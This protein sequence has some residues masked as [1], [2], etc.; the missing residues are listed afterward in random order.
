M[1]SFWTFCF[2]STGS[3]ITTMGQPKIKNVNARRA[4]RP[5]THSIAREASGPAGWPGA[6]A[7]RSVVGWWVAR[8]R[9]PDGPPVLLEVCHLGGRQREEAARVGVRLELLC[10]RRE[11]RRRVGAAGG[12]RRARIV[13][14]KGG[15]PRLKV[16]VR[17]R[18]KVRVRG[19]AARLGRHRRQLCETAPVGLED[20]LRS[21]RVPARDAAVLDVA[22]RLALEQ[23]QRLVARAA[24]P[25]QPAAQPLPESEHK[26]AQPPVAAHEAPTSAPA[27]RRVRARRAAAAAA[28]RAVRHPLSRAAKRK[29]RGRGERP[30]DDA[31]VR[32]ACGG[33]K[34]DADG[35][36]LALARRKLA[37]PVDRV[38]KGRE[39]GE[40]P[41]GQPA[42]ERIHPVS[43]A[44]DERLEL[45]GRGELAGAEGRPV[46]ADLAL[47]L[48]AHDAGDV[49]R[50]QPPEQRLHEAVGEREDRLVLLEGGRAAVGRDEAVDGGHKLGELAA[51]LCTS[52]EQ[53]RG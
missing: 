7:R 32:G 21:A 48:L 2:W 31:G 26:L 13:R 47:V 20:R 30:V 5:S 3:T 17:R 18:G 51:R 28:E 4:R 29:G 24:R 12:R 19:P 53:H 9:F 38:D 43:G 27:R 52:R 40:R 25:H 14:G 8:R 11:R 42:G 6:P 16:D 1:K 34:A 33:G 15:E 22:G 35:A 49:G 45:G 44:K 10:T 41:S 23:Q 50:E 36:L 39:V 46:D 37:R